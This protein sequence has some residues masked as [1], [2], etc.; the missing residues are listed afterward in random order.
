MILITKI[1]HYFLFS[2]DLGVTNK[3][4][5]KNKKKK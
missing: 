1:C 5:K 2:T 4:D 3:Q